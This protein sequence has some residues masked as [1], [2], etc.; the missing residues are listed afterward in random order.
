L[1][2]HVSNDGSFRA[3]SADKGEKLYEVQV[4]RTGMAPPI[5]YEVGGKQYVAFMGGLGRQA[6][7]NGPNDAKVDAPP[8]LY[9]FELDGKVDMPKAAAPPPRP[10][11]G[12]PPPGPAPEQAQN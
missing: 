3:Y 4:G 10:G 1:V 2:F 6:N 12:A 5:T 9:V 7:V 8:M 11:N